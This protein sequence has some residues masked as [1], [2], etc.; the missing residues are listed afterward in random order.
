MKPERWRR[1]E[2]LYHGASAVDESRRDEFLSRECEGD[3]DLRREVE[4]LLAHEKAAARFIESPAM[5]VAARLV[6]SESLQDATSGETLPVSETLSA[7]SVIGPYHLLQLIGEGGMGQVWLAEQ[8]EPVRRRVALKLI[9]VGMD[10][11]EVVARFQ[12]ECQALA[13]M[14][15]PA[16]AKV[17][18]AGSTPEGRPYF[19]MEYVPGLPIST[20]CDQHKLTLRQRLELFIQVCEGVQHAHQKAIIHRDLKASNILVTEV[21][22]KPMPRIID[23]GV[24]KA[25]SQQLTSDT[26][27]TRLGSAVGTL[28]YMS[29]EQADGAGQDIDTRS[30][31]YSLGVVLYELLAGSLPLDFRKLAYDEI[32]RRLREEEPQRPSI[33][34]RTDAGD[35]AVT[36]QKRGVDLPTLARQ[37]RGDADAIALKALEKDR[38]HRYSTASDLAADIERYLSDEPVIAHAPSGIYRAGKYIR[39]HKLGVGVAAAGFL[40]L[41]AFAIVQTIQLRR[42]TRERDRADRITDFMTGMFQVRDAQHGKTVT[43]LDLLGKGSKEIGIGLKND[44]ELQAGMMH[45]MATSYLG[46]GAYPQSESLLESALEIDRR[47]LGSPNPKT[48]SDMTLL[49]Q[50]LSREGR[51]AEAEKTLREAIDVE[52]R[53]LGSENQQTLYSSLILAQTLFFEG[54]WVE[55]ESLYRSTLQTERRVL[56]PDANQTVSTRSSFAILLGEE[57]HFSEVEALQREDLDRD[58][59]LYGS[60]DGSTT[61]AMSNLANTLD[62]ETHFADAE[63]IQREALRIGRSVDGPEHPHT[64]AIMNNLGQTL[65]AE[66]QFAEA[67]EMERD[68]LV[69]ETRTLGPEHPNTL[70]TMTSLATTLQKEGRLKDAEKVTLETLDVERRVL[71]PENARTL[72]N[73]EFLATILGNEG[74][75]ADADELSRETIEAVSEANEA[76]VLANAW[77]SYGCIDAGRGYKDEAIHH[78]QQAVDHGFSDANQ[79][80]SDDDL[81]SLRQDPRFQAL[82]AKIQKNAPAASH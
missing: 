78:L 27:F 72:Y 45:T 81:K 60:E 47:I 55:A 10:T 69:V 5:E 41:A 52:R 7:G 21:N 68:A 14:D 13:L 28:G 19:V 30:D 2:D 58:R 1:I 4:S 15:H 70:A 76:S 73:L 75:H 18:D 64:L 77:Y 57:G 29:P 50:V 8:R 49:A 16:I 6:G 34:V 23:F 32:L 46:L 51:Y 17:F 54:R 37:L 59:R 80:A 20:Y 36:A 53:V 24:A 66:G 56:G 74:L 63:N 22:G 40:L 31:I 43:A 62:Q 25:T 42:I 38:K 3:D 35:S 48:L 12:S 79:M 39:R 65:A 61:A 33:K 9:K 71:G 11:R 67:E 44:P 26:I 82:L